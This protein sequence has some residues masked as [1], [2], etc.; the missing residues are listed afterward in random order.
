[1]V[2]IKKV[3]NND[4]NRKIKQA[5]NELTVNAPIP[6]GK[7]AMLN[8]NVNCTFLLILAFI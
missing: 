3:K 8:S 4:P 1:V 2:N 6:R 7:A 5:G